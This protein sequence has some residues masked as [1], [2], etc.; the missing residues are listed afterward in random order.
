MFPKRHHWYPFP[1]D[2]ESTQGHSAAATI[3]SNK[4]PSD[5]IGYRTHDLPVCTE[6]IAISR[7]ALKFLLIFFPRA[8]FFGGKRA[9]RFQQKLQTN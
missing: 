2:A 4:N 8:A 5:S 6:A 3:K 7:D 1:F 9:I